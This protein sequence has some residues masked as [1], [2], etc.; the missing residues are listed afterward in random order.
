MKNDLNTKGFTLMEVLIAIS[1]LAVGMLAV[2]SLAAGIIKGTYHS[3]RLTAA[4]TLVQE[5]IEEMLRLGYSGTPTADT[6]TVEDYSTI[7]GFPDFRRVTLT[8]VD[9]PSANMKLIE[10][11]VY[12]DSD[13]KSVKVRTFL[14]ESAP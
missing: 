7:T 8:D 14:A 11:T 10:V 1:L 6:L 5:K 9:N 12:W 4:T 3:V 13:N 2:A